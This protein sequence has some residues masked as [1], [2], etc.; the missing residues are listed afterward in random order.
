LHFAA[1]PQVPIEKSVARRGLHAHFTVSTLRRIGLDVLLVEE[2]RGAHHLG[3]EQSSADEYAPLGAVR[4]VVTRMPLQIERW[5]APDLPVRARD[6]VAHL[7]LVPLL[8]DLL[9]RLDL[10][11]FVDVDLDVGRQSNLDL[12]LKQ[13][14]RAR[15][16]AVLP[17]SPPLLH[18]EA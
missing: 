9:T 2:V 3:D 11:V 18:L 7:D 17:D 6:G 12:R 1:Q 4:R 8:I 14:L 16:V 15:S 13:M 5:V 10:K